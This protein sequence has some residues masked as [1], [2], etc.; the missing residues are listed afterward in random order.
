MTGV[1]DKYTTLACDAVFELKV[2]RSKFIAHAFP[3][4]DAENSLK[5]IE[6]VRKELHD[7]RHHPFAYRLSDENSFRFN[8]DGEPSGSAGKPILDAI[9]KHGLRNTLVVVTRYSGGVKL[10]VGGL[11]RAYF[12]A[13]DMCLG[14]AEIKE[15]LI[16]KD[17]TIKFGFKYIGGV[18]NMVAREGI[19]ILEDKSTNNSM[20]VCRVRLGLIDRFRKEVTELTNGS[21]DFV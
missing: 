17:I 11:K 6:S 5:K 7:A 14:S 21:A 9:D 3:A 12:E 4:D 20:L 10:G 13:A 16:T 19:R 2:N 18:M 8:D 15:V 1:K